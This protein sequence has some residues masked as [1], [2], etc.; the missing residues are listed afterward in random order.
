MNLEARGIRVLSGIAGEVR[1]VLTAFTRGALD[2]PR[3]RI[4]GAISK[5]SLPGGAS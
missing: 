2:D 1:E 5:Q 4:P 3:F